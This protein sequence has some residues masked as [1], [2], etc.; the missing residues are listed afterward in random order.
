MPMM[1]KLTITA[2]GQQ[3]LATLKQVQGGVQG[4]GTATATTNVQMGGL[5]RDGKKALG[6]LGGH[7][8]ALGLK[9]GVMAAAAYAVTKVI[10]DFT[11]GITHA[12]E[13]AKKLDIEVVDIVGTMNLGEGAVEGMKEKIKELALALGISTEQMVKFTEKAEELINQGSQNAP[14]IGAELEMLSKTTKKSYAQKAEEMLRKRYEATGIEATEG[15]ATAITRTLEGNER[16]GRGKGAANA[17]F[18]KGFIHGR[19]VTK[20]PQG[21]VGRY[22]VFLNSAEA[23]E[24]REQAYRDENPIMGTLASHWYYRFAPVAISA[25]AWK[26]HYDMTHYGRAEKVIGRSNSVGANPRGQ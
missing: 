26:A 16:L 1:A 5:G 18:E 20:M 17:R 24:N 22:G 8:A 4:V 21:N 2:E 9:F 23:Q 6:I 19:G 13:E 10:E 12:K 11:E 25:L 3:A 7:T 15:E 14:A